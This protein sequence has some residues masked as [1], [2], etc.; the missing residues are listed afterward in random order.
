[1]QICFWKKL[2]NNLQWGFISFSSFQ[3]DK[4]KIIQFLLVFQNLYLPAIFYDSKSLHTTQILHTVI[5][6]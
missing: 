4:K 6:V 1:M 2:L 5:V 3:K